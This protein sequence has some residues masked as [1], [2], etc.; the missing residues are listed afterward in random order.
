MEASAGPT[1]GEEF[2]WSRDR[3][4]AVNT[5]VNTHGPDDSRRP[6]RHG[7][8]AAGTVCPAAER[9]LQPST[10]T[11]SAKVIFST[12]VIPAGFE[13]SPEGDFGEVRRFAFKFRQVSGGL[14]ICVSLRV[15]RV[16]RLSPVC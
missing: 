16:Y 3:R 5:G 14:L 11:V 1:G 4:A 2:H 7:P 15:E 12:E 9:L 13:R 6:T 10:S 8:T